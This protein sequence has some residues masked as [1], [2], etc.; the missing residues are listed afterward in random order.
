[1]F[2]TRSYIIV[3]FAFLFWL[4][5]VASG[6]GSFEPE[7]WPE[8]PVAR[9]EPA[10][11]P[12]SEPQSEPELVIAE[13]IA[14]VEP[15][16]APEVD[17][18]AI[19]DALSEAAPAETAPLP[20]LSGA[21]LENAFS[22]TEP[23]AP[24]EISPEAIVAAPEPAPELVRI[25]GSRVNIRSGPG[26]ENGVVTTLDGGIVVEVL[27]RAENGWVEVRLPDDFGIGW[28]SGTLVEPVTE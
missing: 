15:E 26:T 2:G 3:T 27:S 9:V 25:A 13:E 18:A 7:E 6:G 14:P 5:Y 28:V 23:V 1:M 22:F 20:D 17:G 21:G 11:E 19:L 12:Q 4:Y 16:P 8:V 10:P 24:I